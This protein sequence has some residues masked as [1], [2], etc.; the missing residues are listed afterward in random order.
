M[1][2]LR[3]AGRAGRP[4][5]RCDTFEGEREEA[6]KVEWKSLDSN[7]VFSKFSEFDGIDPAKITLQR[8]PA[9]PR[10]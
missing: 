2:D 10:T 5:C 9:S 4:F 3:E 7:E 1:R 8:S 6:R